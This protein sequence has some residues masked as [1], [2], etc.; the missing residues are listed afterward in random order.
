MVQIK[1]G[2]IM[3]NLLKQPLFWAWS[4]VGLWGVHSIYTAFVGH[5]VGL[6][7][8]LT[9]LVAALLVVSAMQSRRRKNMYPTR[10]LIDDTLPDSR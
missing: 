7:I 4:F 1:Q 6:V 8:S 3:S 10:H 5:W 9:G 2:A